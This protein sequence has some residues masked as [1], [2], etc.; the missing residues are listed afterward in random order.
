M[1]WFLPALTIFLGLMVFTGIVIF[2]LKARKV[3]TKLDI[4]I[5]APTIDIGFS[6]RKFTEGYA[7]GI[8]KSQKPCKNGCTRIEMYPTDID[9]SENAI[10]PGLKAFMVKDE[11]IK[12]HA[13]GEKGSYREK[14]QLIDRFRLDLPE[15][16]RDTN[17]GIEMEK[18]GQRAF[19]EATIGKTVRE[20]DE[21]IHEALIDT[22]RVGLS[23]M[24]LAQLKEETAHL[25][26]GTSPEPPKEGKE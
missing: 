3:F 2:E 26:A 17:Y 20:G 15:K 22:T 4:G 10:H 24:K 13:R 5:N 25:R 21:A 9:Q 18:S 8:V 19:L 11:F 6:R 16:L 7:E 14:I 23:K 1:S 12:R